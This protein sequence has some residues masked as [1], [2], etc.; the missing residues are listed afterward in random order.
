MSENKI[1]NTVS[2]EDEADPHEVV[3]KETYTIYVMGKSIEQFR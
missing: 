2:V 3:E 1:T